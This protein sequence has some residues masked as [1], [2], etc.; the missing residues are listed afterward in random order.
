MSA[1]L[2]PRRPDPSAADPAAPDHILPDQLPAGA[3][4]TGPAGV[5]AADEGRIDDELTG[6]DL[7]GENMPEDAEGPD[8]LPVGRLAQGVDV[9]KEKVRTLPGA[10]GCYRMLNSRGDVLYVGKA[11]DLK[12]RVTSYTQPYR[13]PLRIQR[14]IAETVT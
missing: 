4:D 5:S 1:P 7:A 12:K 13:Q 3:A 10:P 8:P 14:M 6:D 9:I 2:P 11:K